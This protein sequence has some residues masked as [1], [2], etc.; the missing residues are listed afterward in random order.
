MK[1]L[2]KS[3]GGR[4]VQVGAASHGSWVSTVPLLWGT[5]WLMPDYRTI[6]C[7]SPEMIHAYER[8]DE[9]LFKD[10]VLAESP[11]ADL[12]SG[13]PFL[14]GSAGIVTTGASALA[15]VRQIDGLD[16]GFVATPPG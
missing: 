4:Q 11:G 2:T 5:R 16:W 9:L 15:F 7:D 10:R 14:T 3:E 6:T 12:G 1:R 13:N 8:Y